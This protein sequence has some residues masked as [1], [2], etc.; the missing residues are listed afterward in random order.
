MAGPMRAMPA[1]EAL[2]RLRP[3]KSTNKP[4][5]TLKDYDEDEEFLKA[6]EKEFNEGNINLDDL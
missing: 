5:R 1:M 3:T 2:P 6:L 4:V